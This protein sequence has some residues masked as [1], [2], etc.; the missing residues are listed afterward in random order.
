M[1]I[2]DIT[3]LPQR[4]PD[5]PTLYYHYNTIRTF[6]HFISL[7]SVLIFFIVLCTM[8]KKN[9]SLIKAVK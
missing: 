7:S 5:Y 8:S 6:S 2:L 3:R 1:H 4:V 9:N